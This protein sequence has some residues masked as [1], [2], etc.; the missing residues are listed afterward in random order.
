MVLE[1]YLTD[2]AEQAHHVPP[3]TTQR[4]YLDACITCG[5][6]HTR[7]NEPAI[8]PVGHGKPNTQIFHVWAA[9]LRFAVQCFTDTN[10]QLA[11]Q[12]FKGITLEGPRDWAKLPIPKALFVEGGFPTR[13][14]KVLADA[15]GLS[16]PNSVPPA[17]GV[18][19]QPRA[20]SP[21]ARR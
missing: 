1:H 7:L 20:A 6:T 11:R 17:E 5:H 13:D 18:A 8:A 4:G 12:A 10:E 3:A 21:A 14:G 15:A 19:T 16:A 9:H 2:T